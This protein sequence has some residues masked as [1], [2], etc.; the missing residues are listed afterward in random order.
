MPVKKL[1]NTKMRL[2]GVLTPKQRQKLTLAMLKDVITATKSSMINHIVVVGSDPTIEDLTKD[3]DVTYLQEKSPNLNSSLKQATQWSIKNHAKTVL[4]LPADIPLITA[5]DINQI[6]KLGADS[7]SLV[8]VSSHNNGTNALLQ[9]PPNIISPRFGPNSFQKHQTE[10]T[11]KGVS[12]IIYES[13]SVALDIDSTE[14]LDI[15]LKTENQTTTKAVL[16]EIKMD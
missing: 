15:L 3:F 11:E 12:P 1:T 7:P 2:S 6:L 13:D 4:I 5:N 9:N 14:D 8:I 10:A 16:A